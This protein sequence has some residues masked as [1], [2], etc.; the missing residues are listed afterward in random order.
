MVVLEDS[1]VVLGTGEMGGQAVIPAWEDRGDPPSAGDGREK[2]FTGSDRRAGRQVGGAGPG[3]AD[4]TGMW[5]RPDAGVLRR[6][7]RE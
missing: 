4:G 6:I 7:A 5:D 1:A 2:P 3:H